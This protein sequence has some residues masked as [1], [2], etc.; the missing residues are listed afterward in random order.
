LSVRI[1]DLVSAV[2]PLTKNYWGA[3]ALPSL[4]GG[5]AQGRGLEAIPAAAL[6]MALILLGLHELLLH[7]GAAA[8]PQGTEGR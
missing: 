5:L 8:H 4:A 3:A 7:R 2:F 6:A 1:L